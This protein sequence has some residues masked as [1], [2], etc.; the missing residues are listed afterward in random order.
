MRRIIEALKPNTLTI[1]DQQTL[2]WFARSLLNILVFTA[3]AG[4]IRLVSDSVQFQR[5]D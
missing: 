2:F 5:P 1:P 3:I 4:S